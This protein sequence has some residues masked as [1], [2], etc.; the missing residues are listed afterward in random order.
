MTVIFI[1]APYLILVQLS[2]QPGFLISDEIKI[3]TLDSPHVAQI[4]SFTAW[5]A[6]RGL[7]SFSQLVYIAEHHGGQVGS[8]A[9]AREKEIR[10]SRFKQQTLK[11]IMS[12][13]IVD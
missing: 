2:L 12:G 10:G 7:E 3:D 13:K 8:N 11:W 6:L 5:G 9:A 1:D 4:I